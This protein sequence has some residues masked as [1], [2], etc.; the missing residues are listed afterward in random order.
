MNKFTK[1]TSATLYMYLVQYVT[2]AGHNKLDH[3][4]VKVIC[5]M[6]VGIYDETDANTAV[7]SFIA[8]QNG[9][10]TMFHSFDDKVNMGDMTPTEW[11]LSLGFGRIA[12][13]MGHVLKAAKSLGEE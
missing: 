9:Y 1:D 7:T 11:E 8:L 13:I 6:F 4:M 12:L 2:R 10:E 3:E 5:L